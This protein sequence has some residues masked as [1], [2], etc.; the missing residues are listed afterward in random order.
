MGSF[1]GKGV[2][3]TMEEDGTSEE[4]DSERGRVWKKK[5]AVKRKLG[6]RGRES[7]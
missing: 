6:G 2:K 3:Y 4:E 1:N 5:R 7:I